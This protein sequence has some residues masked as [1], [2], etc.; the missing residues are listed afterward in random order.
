M[1][2]TWTPP[3]PVISI[4]SSGRDTAST[5]AAQPGAVEQA[6][7]AGVQRVAAQLVAREAGAI[8]E[9]DAGA[10][11]RE[12]DGGDRSGRPGPRDEHVDHED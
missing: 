9:Q 6:Q 8:D 4:P 10:G 2:R 3:L 7:G 1:P 11:A 5:R 12:P